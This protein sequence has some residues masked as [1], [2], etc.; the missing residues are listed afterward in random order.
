MQMMQKR[1]GMRTGVAPGVMTGAG[2]WSVLAF[3]LNLTWEVAHVRLYSIWS[4]EDGMSVAWALLH[5]SLGDAAIA[6]ATFAPAGIALLN[7]AKL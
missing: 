6:L 4:A 3:I 1:M 7:R 5:R 2:L